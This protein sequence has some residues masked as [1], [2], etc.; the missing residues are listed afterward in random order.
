LVCFPSP[1]ITGE[2]SI[3]WEGHLAVDNWIFCSLIYKAPEYKKV[4]KYGNIQILILPRQIHA[5]I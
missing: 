3:S 5:A 2:K 4:L 1:E